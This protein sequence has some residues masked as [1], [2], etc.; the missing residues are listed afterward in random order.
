MRFHE[1]PITF[2]ALALGRH[3]TIE[4]YD[5]NAH[6]L[7]D[8]KGMEKIFTEAAEISGATVLES[9]FHAFQP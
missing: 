2:Q 5:C 1:Q 6:T 8:V 4:Y 3:L 7:A 9:S